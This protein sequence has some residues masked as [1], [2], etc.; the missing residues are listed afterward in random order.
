MSEW[1]CT[2]FEQDV[3]EM[4]YMELA[5]WITACR[6]VVLECNFDNHESYVAAVDMFTKEWEE[7][8][9]QNASFFTN[10]HKRVK[11]ALAFIGYT[12]RLSYEFDYG[13][14]SSATYTDFKNIHQ[15][16]LSEGGIKEIEQDFMESYEV[17]K[18]IF[19]AE[20][21]YKSRLHDAV[22]DQ[23][24]RCSN[25]KVRAFKNG[26]G[27]KAASYKEFIEKCEKEKYYF[28]FIAK[29]KKNSYKDVFKEFDVSTSVYSDFI[30]ENKC[31]Q[32]FGKKF[33]INLGFALSLNLTLVEQLLNYNGYSIKNKSR[34]FD[35][36]CEK[37]FRI[38]FGREY[39]IALIDKCNQEIA[40]K[41]AVY[42]PVPTI[43][44]EKKSNA[45]GNSK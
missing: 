36:I 12:Q 1:N 27:V 31:E 34:E 7:F 37:A 23:A 5:D 21:G 44:K 39:T 4:N 10:K 26:A 17:I 29:H 9:R 41:Y 28:E 20:D 3:T 8:Y 40:D 42:K 33:F 25:I 38:G 14:K 22:L 24:F 6:S 30:S 35:K 19:S 45:T 16:D 18:N 13:E 15:N 32:E 2:L 11:K 43:R